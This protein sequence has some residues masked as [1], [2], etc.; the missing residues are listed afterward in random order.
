MKNLFRVLIIVVLFLSFFP[1]NESKAASYSD[2]TP[3]HRFYEDVMYLLQKGVIKDSSRYGVDNK[4]TREEVAVMIGK[5]LGLDGT[6]AKTKFKDVPASLAS[7]GYIN[8]AV[9]AGIISGHL[10]GTFK[11]KDLVT[12]GQMAIFIARGFNLTI[13][14]KVPY[15][16]VSPSSAAYT[17]I[18]KTV[19]AGITAGFPDGT[20]KPQDN[21]TRGQLS[22][23][24][25]RSMRLNE[26]TA[27]QM[28]VH[29][30]DVGQGD[31]ILIQSPNGKNMLIDGGTKSAGTKV[32]SFIKS[33]GITKL[34]YVVA[35]HPDAD[36]IGGLIS[37]LN[38]ISVGT[39]IDSGKSHTTETYYEMLNLI[40]VKNIPFK[41]PTAGDKIAL[42]S[43]LNL[44]VLNSA[45]ASDDTNEASIVLK[46]TYGK[47][48]FLFMGDA[49]TTTEAE[50]VAKYDLKSTVLKAG[51]HGSSTSTSQL[52][53]NEV[54]PV[55]TTLSYG[56][57]NSYGHPHSEVV[58]RLKAAGSKLYNTVDHCDISVLTSG[59]GHTVSN[60][61]TPTTTPPPA[62]STAVK[63]VSK[64]LSAEI[65]GIKNTGSTT[66]DITD[67]TLVSVS[68]NQTY[69][70]P[71]YN[72]EAGKTVYVT[73]GPN[74]KSATGYLKWTTANIWLNSGDPAKLLN[75]QGAVV[76]ELQ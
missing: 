72:L 41:V 59:N 66:V 14:A 40:D 34:D 25:A 49:D 19:H 56:K 33:K 8:A 4:V 5:A 12:R 32:V 60:T 65:V 73:S 42:D 24:V 37:V 7:S 23:F 26:P 76:S 21:I 31:S 10:D 11:P 39:F 13:E 18:R 43:A 1:I 68:G 27:K 74:A 64:D 58:N 53:V 9:D 30:I 75:A 29:F 63:I 28:K 62:T 35:T 51:H 48:T 70:F 71:S 57:E 50:L 45:E 2:V 44:Q 38:S 6:P 54:K 46:M 15:K 20:F 17:Y 61:C 36:H 47:E 69:K 16:D 3:N 22:A 67:W 52:F 55:T